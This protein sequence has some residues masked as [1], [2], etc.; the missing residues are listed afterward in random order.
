M[1]KVHC[2][3][4]KQIPVV[5]L[6]D[7]IDSGRLHMLDN[8]I[9]A[10]VQKRINDRMKY[11]TYEQAQERYG[12]GETTLRKMAIDCGALYKVGRAARI[13]VD[14]MDKYFETFLYESGQ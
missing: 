3:L 4:R 9:V 13:K 14:T 2:L 8:Q 5:P 11:I 6:A 7:N 1:R 12:L 10:K